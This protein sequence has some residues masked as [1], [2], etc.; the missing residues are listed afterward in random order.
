MPHKSKKL[1]IAISGIS[2][3]SCVSTIENALS[4]FSGVVSANVN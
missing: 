3:A 2:C 4:S 1:I